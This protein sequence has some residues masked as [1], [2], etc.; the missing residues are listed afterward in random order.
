MSDIDIMARTLYGEARGEGLE[1]M[2]AVASVIMN[3]CRPGKWYCGYINRNGKKIPSVAQTCLKRC[4]FS[5]WN[6]DDPNREKISSVTAKDAV[7][8]QCLL[9]AQRA[10]SGE[11][12]DSTGGAV[13]YHHIDCKPYWAVGKKPCYKCGHHLFYREE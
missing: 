7:F 1:G 13:Y 2:E 4:Q 6:R 12:G 8:R 3:R 9:I 11:L 5:C 10:L